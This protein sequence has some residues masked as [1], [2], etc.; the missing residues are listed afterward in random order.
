[1]RISKDQDAAAIEAYRIYFD[2]YIDGD[3]NAIA[4]MLNDDYTQIGSAESEVFFNKQEAL[5]F[6][7]QTIGQVAGRAEIRNRVIRSEWLREYVMVIDLFDMY[8][9]AEDEWIFY[10]KFRASTLMEYKDEQWRFVHQHSSV[11]D[12]RTDE[13]DN[14]AIE[15][16]SAENL[17]L[18]D[19]IKRRTI[20]L[21]QKNRELE[22]ETSLEKIRSSAL[23]MHEPDDMLEVCRII[24]EQLRILGVEEIRNVQTVIINEPESQY[25]NYQYFVPYGEKVTEV[26]D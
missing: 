11:P 21:E 14:I 13:G 9:R 24:A 17:Q 16:I 18:R 15:K 22:I 10:S 8:V 2:S 5:Q 4:A 1:M 23:S 19:A 25:V 26:V 3:V 12:V 6:L 7:N 20:E